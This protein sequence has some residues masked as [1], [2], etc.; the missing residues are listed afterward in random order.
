MSILIS[1]RNKKVEI[2]IS[3]TYTKELSYTFKSKKELGGVIEE[4]ISHKN[5][6]YGRIPI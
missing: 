5:R 4:L 3:Y 2:E 1:S 6:V